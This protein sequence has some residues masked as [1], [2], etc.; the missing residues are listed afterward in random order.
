MA[1]IIK[2]QFNASTLKASYDVGTN[3]AQVLN[4]CGPDCDACEGT[5]WA[6]GETPRYVT[7][8]IS[9]VTDCPGEST[10]PDGEYELTQS[11][12]DVCQWRYQDATYKITWAP[13]LGVLSHFVVRSPD[14]TDLWFIHEP[15]SNC[16]TN[17]ASDIVI[18]D[19][20][21]E[22]WPGTWVLAYGGTYSIT[23]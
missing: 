6:N 18:G 16:V 15:G 23:W 13:A 5:L 9:G 2:L 14:T 3:K 19:C 20:A 11:L 21:T 17:G 1:C 10:A 8:T 22:Y 7:A 12:G 4:P